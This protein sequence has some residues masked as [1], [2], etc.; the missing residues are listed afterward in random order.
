METNMETFIPAEIARRSAGILEERK[1]SG[2]LD[3]IESIIQSCCSA[4][5]L[6]HNILEN[7]AVKL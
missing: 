7:E 3:Y 1:I 5:P 2:I 6:P 4:T